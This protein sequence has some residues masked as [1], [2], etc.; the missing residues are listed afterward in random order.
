[1]VESVAEDRAEAVVA[2]AAS[3][4]MVPMSIALVLLANWLTT[5]LVSLVVVL[6]NFISLST[7]T[8]LKVIR[9]EEFNLGFVS[10]FSV[11]VY[12]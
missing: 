4:P 8:C 12:I 6:M 7:D 5:M 9:R 1:M 11:L 10:V 3:V 2:S